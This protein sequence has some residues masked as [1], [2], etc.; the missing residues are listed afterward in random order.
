ME[1][2]AYLANVTARSFCFAAAA[3]GAVWL[4]HV[5]TAAARH[6]VMTVV[7]SGMLL[8]AALAPALPPLP[9]RVLR[10]ERAAVAF[11]A[12][13]YMMEQPAPLEPL[14]AAQMPASSPSRWRLH[15]EWPTATAILYYAVTAALLLRL[16]YGYLFARRLVAAS[17]REGLVGQ[18][19][20]LPASDIE[21]E[22]SPTVYESTWISVPVTVGWLHPK[23]LLPAGW[24]EWAPDKL[25]A[26]L[27]HERMHIQRADW[28]IGTLAAVN[29]C[30]FWFNPLAWWL[31]RKMALLAEQACDDAAVLATGA[32]ESYAEALLDMAA[33]VRTG[34]GRIAWEAMAMARTAEV[35]TRIERILDEARQI[36]RGLTRARWAALLACSLPLVYLA[37]VVQ[38]VP[39]R[40]APPA[41]QA[42]LAQPAHSPMPPA[43]EIAQ[44]QPAVPP[45]SQQ[46]GNPPQPDRRY[47]ALFFETGMLTPPDVPKYFASFQEMNSG[48]ARIDFTSGNNSFQSVMKPGDFVAVMSMDAGGALRVNQDFTDDQNLVSKAVQDL[49]HSQTIPKYPETDQ[50][51]KAL[52]DAMSILSPIAGRKALVYFAAGPSLPQMASSEQ[53]RDLADLGRT[54]DTMLYSMVMFNGRTFAAY[55]TVMRLPPYTYVEPLSVAFVPSLDAAYSLP[56][57]PLVPGVKGDVE[58]RVTLGPGGHVKDAHFLSGNPSL[59]SKAREMLDRVVYEPPGVSH[60]NVA[61]FETKAYVQ[62]ALDRRPPTRAP[63][64]VDLA[65]ANPDSHVSQE[66]DSPPT[67]LRKVYPDYP[68][69]VRAS[70]LQGI[71]TLTA[72]IG[73]DG[74]PK[75]IQVLRAPPGGSDEAA[76]R[77]AALKAA[78]QW[79]FAPARD[80][81][82]QPVESPVTLQMTLRLI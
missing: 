74:I 69:E 53:W 71:V 43:P 19:I 81:S 27:A 24:N 51:V 52:A 49:A 8:L 56:R 78:S 55:V 37:T 82:G 34:R 62:F 26:V 63:D 33:A 42:D 44:A 25:E 15:I 57:A 31:E 80:N 10:A 75:D 65:E 61:G 70:G 7:A 50:R 41:A 48:N 5:K 76:L 30:V 13:I 17:R 32:R 23:I 29:R 54:T 11:P 60:E 77:A 12:P 1:T 58:F 79:R 45:P 66:P 72:T 40:S 4:F 36:P 38:P 21:G 22:G 73:T 28:A 6:A 39:A 67:L 59:E 46:P 18:A 35:R 9:V 68:L 3:L 47:V 14:T 16:I 20:R 2:L 64:V